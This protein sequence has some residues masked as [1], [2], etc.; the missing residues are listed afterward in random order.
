M[1]RSSVDRDHSKSSA[2]P[3]VS[4]SSGSL[5]AE[6]NIKSSLMKRLTQTSKPD[7]SKKVTVTFTD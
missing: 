3:R 1:H 2:K 7:L 5:D 6:I 4:F